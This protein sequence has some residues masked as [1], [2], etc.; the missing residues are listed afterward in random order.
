M[1]Y[2]YGQ[3][4]RMNKSIFP[5]VLF[6]FTLPW[7]KP[8]LASLLTSEAQQIDTG[9][10][11]RRTQRQAPDIDLTMVADDNGGQCAKK[12]QVNVHN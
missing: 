5:S 2:V 8:R 6:F 1:D 9:M 3:V 10:K 4:K 12:L 7:L 11:E